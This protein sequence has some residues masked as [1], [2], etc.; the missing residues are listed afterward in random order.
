MNVKDYHTYE[1]LGK[2]RDDAIGEAFDKVARVVGLG[3]PGGPKIDK[4]AKERYSLYS[5]TNHAFGRFRF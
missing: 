4:L 2:T 3:Y 1:I 5:A